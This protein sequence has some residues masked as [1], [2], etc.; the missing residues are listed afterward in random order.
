MGGRKGT[1]MPFIH[2]GKVDVTRHE[3][4]RREAVGR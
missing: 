4:G 3:R 2:L 1:S